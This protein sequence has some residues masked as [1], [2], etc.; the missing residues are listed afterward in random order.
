MLPPSP[1]THGWG[2]KEGQDAACVTLSPAT[3]DLDVE[4]Q[5]TLAD[6]ELP[7]DAIDS[8]ADAM[9]PTVEEPEPAGTPLASAPTP[10]TRA[11]IGPVWKN[12]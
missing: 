1:F 3:F 9:A 4:D 7:S 12:C 8:D 11:P 2:R 5:A 6:W 10:Q